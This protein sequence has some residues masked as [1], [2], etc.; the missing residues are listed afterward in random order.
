MRWIEAGCLLVVTLAVVWLLFGLKHLVDD[1]DRNLNS[2]ARELQATLTD[3]HRVVLATG[4]A[5]SNIEKSSRKWDARENE[6]AN[7]TSTAISTLNASLLEVSTF[8]STAT[9]LLK[10]QQQSLNAL[11][12]TASA[13]ISTMGTSVAALSPTA[14]AALSNLNSASQELRDQLSDPAIRATLINLQGTSEQV[15]GIAADAHVETGL[16]VSKTREA[17]KARNRFLSVLQMLGGGV[18]NG[19]ELVYY[20]G[21]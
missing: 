7:Q 13:S 3:A 8:T 11:E 1:A 21:H 5:V 6:I 19:A 9:S 14:Q 4:G 20:L 15:E 10:S 17:F 18:I 12:S 16:I 2:N